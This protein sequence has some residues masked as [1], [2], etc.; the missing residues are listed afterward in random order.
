MEEYIGTC[1]ECGC[2]V[3]CENGFLDGI[4]EQGALFCFA[5]AEEY[6]E[7]KQKKNTTS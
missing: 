4:Y 2:P 1:Q 6:S 5:C 7:N 3:Y